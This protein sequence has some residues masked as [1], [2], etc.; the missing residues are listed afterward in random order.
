M[1]DRARPAVQICP[2]LPSLP[3]TR[4]DLLRIGIGAALALPLMR[5]PR[6]SAQPIRY[7][8]IGTGTTGGTYFLIGGILANAISSPPGALPCDRGGSCGVPG[9][10]GVAQSTPGAVENIRLMRA[11]RLESSLVQADT[12]YAAF[13][14]EAPFDKDGAFADLRAIANLYTETIHLVVLGDSGIARVRDLKGK[15]VALGEQ[16]SGTLV[17][18]RALLAAYGLSEKTVKPAYL[19]PGAAGDRLVAG[20]I[21][22]FF[23]VGG[24]P[25]PAVADLARRLPIRLL[26][27]ADD[28]ADRLRKRLPLFSRSL[29][30][31]DTYTGV[32]AVQS[33][34]IGAQWM[35]R[36]SIPADLVRGITRTL[37]HPTSQLLLQQGHP[38]GTSIRIGNALQGL[39]VPLH[40]GAEAYY[41]EA[42]LLTGRDGEAS[43]QTARTV[44]P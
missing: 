27:F 2:P 22:A 5:A 31:A 14:G 11:G 12:A 1:S 37:W 30:E 44:Q 24:Y 34:G 18:A 42:G 29:I 19:S 7:F 15:R 28:E 39:A 38:R 25:L 6:V 4:R 8:Q 10:I 40:P 36:A 3:Q 32:A 23:I 9:L 35:V 33:L 20:D 26:G 13:R 21:D 43:A 41:R 17:T 16:G